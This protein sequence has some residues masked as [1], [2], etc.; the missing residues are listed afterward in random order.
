MAWMSLQTSSSSSTV[1]TRV[2]PSRVHWPLLSC[3]GG[4]AKINST[5]KTLPSPSW[6]STWMTPPISSTRF[7]VMAIP[8]PVPWMPLEVEVNSREKGSKM[9]LTNSGLMPMPLSLTAKQRRTYWEAVWGRLWTTNRISPPSG[10][11]LTAL[12]RR[13]SRI[14]LRRSLSPISCSGGQPW[15]WNSRC[16]FLALVWGRRMVYNSSS[17]SGRLNWTV[18]REVFPLSILLMSSTSLMR[19]RRC[20]PEADIFRVYSRTFS[21]WSTSRSIRAVKPM[22]AFMGVR[23]SWDILARKWLL[24]SLALLA[25]SRASWRFWFIFRSWVRSDMTMTSLL[26]PWSSSR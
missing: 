24:A 9:V 21:G 20:W 4:R 5:V 13:F 8:R 26:R 23:I 3:W 16:C 18:F 10:V 7:L 14:W 17:S 15:T 22:M 12:E 25:A 6:L 2:I 19:L 1:S 11:Y